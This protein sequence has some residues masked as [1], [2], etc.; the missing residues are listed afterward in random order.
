MEAGSNSMKLYGE[1]ILTISRLKYLLVIAGATGALLFAVSPQTSP[2]LSIAYPS[3]NT[4]VHRGQ[5]VNVTVTVA[6]QSTF[7]AI[8]IVGDGPLGVSS[9]ALRKPPYKLTIQIPAGIKP[10]SYN[11]Q[12]VGSPATGP[13]EMSNPVPLSITQ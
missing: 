10:G 4:V 12:A 1:L 11:L 7:R 5:T 2:K 13:D 6:A 9:Q 3:A 8:Y